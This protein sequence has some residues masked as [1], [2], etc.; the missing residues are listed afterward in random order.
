MYKYIYVYVHVHVHI[1]IY[2]QSY[3][4]VHTEK[5]LFRQLAVQ[6][7]FAYWLQLPYEFDES[8]S[9]KFQ[10]KGLIWKQS[11]IKFDI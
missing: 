8:T 5:Y 11:F 10:E 4:I 6:V 7:I 3:K 9:E 2:N 1:Y